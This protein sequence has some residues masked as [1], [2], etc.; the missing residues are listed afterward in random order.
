LSLWRVTC[1]LRRFAV[2]RRLGSVSV[3]HFVINGRWVGG[4]GGVGG[5][6]VLCVVGVVV[7]FVVW[8]GGW[9]QDSTPYLESAPY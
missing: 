6:C 7:V 3:S 1:R 8:G 2:T 4:A 9:G 5:W